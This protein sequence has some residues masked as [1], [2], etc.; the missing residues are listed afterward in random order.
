MLRRYQ[1]LAAVLLLTGAAVFSACSDTTGV[2]TGQASILLAG[3]GSVA[4]STVPA[5]LRLSLGDV[6]VAAVGS[7]DL[8]VTR[9]DI[10]RTGD[11]SEAEGDGTGEGEGSEGGE[12]GAG[13]GGGWVTLDLG[14]ETPI[15]LM[16]L[17]T[18]GGV[19]VASGSL[20]AGFYNQVRLYF[21]TSTLTLAQTIN[22]GGQ[23]LDPGTYEIRIPSAEQS[24][25]KIQM[26]RVEVVGGATE[27]ILL[28]IATT[29]SIG[30][31]VWNAT[32]FQL[33]PV[34]HK[35]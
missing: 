5:G 16:S 9:V 23:D 19:E 13:T 34:M 32:G 27:A 7:I 4:A 26:D 21:S 33:S 1:T 11:G 2:E 31:L 10:H 14:T 12:S 18:T 24:G 30:S 8:A 25:Y 15:D 6:P 20:V 35:R 22:V 17:P 28:E 29:A 3:D